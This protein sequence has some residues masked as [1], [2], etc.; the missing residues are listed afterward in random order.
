MLG[1]CPL[2]SGSKGNSIF[3][4]S[5]KTKILIDAGL[6][7]R[8][9]CERLASIGVDIADIDAIIV[10]HEHSDHIAGIKTLSQKYSIP[11]LANTETAKGIVEQLG[12]CPKFKIFSTGEPFTFGDITI[13][14]FTVQHDTLDPVMFTL[15]IDTIKL[16]ICTDLGFAT[17]LVQHQLQAC[18][19]LYLE[20]NHEPEMV[21]ASAR[22]PFLKQRILGR[23]GHLS[24]AECGRLLCRVA[25]P[26]LKHV[27]L[28]HL[29]RECNAPDKAMQ[30]VR[31]TISLEGITINLD[32]APQDF[33]GKIIHF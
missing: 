8:A 3:V 16:G 28:A 1:Y 13:H 33:I 26:G 15:K 6:S 5:P 21:H 18:D 20:S 11:V 12:F 29:S 19:Y 14:P 9:T 25:H 27:H 32:V 24:N 10:S 22:P 17:T 23:S 30:V 4:G 2:A 7:A 31:E